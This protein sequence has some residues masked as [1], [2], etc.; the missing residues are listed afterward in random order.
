MR[1]DGSDLACFVTGA[2]D[3][4]TGADWVQPVRLPLDSFD[5]VHASLRDPFTAQAAA[6]VRIRLRTRASRIGVRVEHRSPRP[7]QTSGPLGVPPIVYD[8]LVDGRLYDRQTVPPVG[9]ATLSFSGFPV[10]EKVVELWLPPAVGVRLHSLSADAEVHPVLAELPRWVV[11]GSSITH[12]AH[13]PGPTAT[14]PAIAATALGWG[15]VNLGFRGG[16]HL[17]PF[18]ARAIAATPADF[19][20]LELGI[21]IHNG[22]TM[23]ERT[24][25]S[26]VQ[27]FLQNIRD[28]H[29]HVPITV[30][31]PV[32][33]GEREDS[34]VSV[35]LRPGKPV[36]TGDLTVRRVRE[37]L[38]EVVAVRR[39]R[40]DAAIEHLDGLTLLGPADAHHLADGLHPDPVGM[41]LMGERYR[42]QAG[43]RPSA[44]AIGTSRAS[45]R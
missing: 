15:H 37:V 41:R 42:E 14:W 39:R 26:A 8:L 23:R 9:T 3:V 20:T 12:C 13:A 38:A 18:V 27:G 28:G 24:F 29:P 2:L 33:S 30:V 5:L 34:P 40:G 31:S 32:F 36:L 1:L 4:E 45:Q 10:G 22:Q 25:G 17:E 44:R 19:I 21:N 43:L 11:H 16:C 6:G 35:P 7:E